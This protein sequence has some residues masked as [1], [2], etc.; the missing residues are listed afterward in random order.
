MLKFAALLALASLIPAFVEAQASLYGQCGGIGW[1]MLSLT[2]HN[3]LI[4]TQILQLVLQPVYQE[5]HAKYSMLIIHS[6]CMY[7][8]VQATL[9]IFILCR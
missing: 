4:L 1:S 6:A 2:H 8:A 3:Y 7:F 5:Q 9:P